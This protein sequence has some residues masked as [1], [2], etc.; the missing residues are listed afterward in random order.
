[1]ATK[2]RTQNWKGMMV[3]NSEATAKPLVSILA[4]RTV[5]PMWLAPLS[6]ALTDEA[7]SLSSVEPS[8]VLS[9]AWVVKPTTRTALLIFL[10]SRLR[11]TMYGPLYFSCLL[12][13]QA[14]PSPSGA[15]PDV[16]VLL[17]CDVCARS[18][19]VA[20]DGSWFVNPATCRSSTMR[21]TLSTPFTVN[22]TADRTEGTR[23]ELSG[24]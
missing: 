16:A 18:H 7:F 9:T 2:T 20:A 14:R 13:A 24:Q 10:Y 17:P 19:L 5:V 23:V 4:A 6:F 11:A 22:V 1:M 15:A 3:T 8:S 21:L 12:S